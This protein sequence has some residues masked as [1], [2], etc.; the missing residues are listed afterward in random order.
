MRCLLSFLPNGM[1]MQKRTRVDVGCSGGWNGRRIMIFLFKDRCR[2]L[3][4]IISGLVPPLP[5]CGGLVYPPVVLS[6]WFVGRRRQGGWTEINSHS[7]TL[8]HRRLICHSTWKH[9]LQGGFQKLL[10]LEIPHITWSDEL[11]SVI[12]IFGLIERTIAGILMF[13]QCVE[14]LMFGLV[15]GWASRD[16]TCQAGGLGSIPGPGQTYV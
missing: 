4:K 10:P 8:F 6:V 12:S 5:I 2:I 15:D 9:V 3:L 16:A 7:S 1:G 11:C 14:T 13:R